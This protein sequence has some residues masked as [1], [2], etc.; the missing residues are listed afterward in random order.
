MSFES[1]SDVSVNEGVELMKCTGG[2]EEEEESLLPFLPEYPGVP[3][4]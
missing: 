4:S 3:K 2:H 1:D